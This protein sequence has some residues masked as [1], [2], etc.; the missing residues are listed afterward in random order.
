MRPVGSEAPGRWEVG[1][2]TPSRPDAPDGQYLIYNADDQ[3][4]VPWESTGRPTERRSGCGNRWWLHRRRAQP[5]RWSGGGDAGSAVAR[6]GRCDDLPAGP[7][8]ARPERALRGEAGRCARNTQNSV[9]TCSQLARI[10]RHRLLRG[11]GDVVLGRA[12]RSCSASVGLGRRTALGAIG[13]VALGGVVRIPHEQRRP[14]SSRRR[15]C[16]PRPR[17]TDDGA[18]G[19]VLAGMVRLPPRRRPSLPSCER[20]TAARRRRRRTARRRWRR[21]DKRCRRRGATESVSP[22]VGRRRCGP[23]PMPLPT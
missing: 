10:F 12:H 2:R 14:R 1:G 20:R 16:G 21:R 7:E 23:P 8:P 4:R 19:H 11:G 3:R 15:R 17:A 5:C 18:P 13:E 22:T 6:G 9:A